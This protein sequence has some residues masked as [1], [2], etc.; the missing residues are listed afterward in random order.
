MS[1][2][3]KPIEYSSSQLFGHE[4]ILSITNKLLTQS[5]IRFVLLIDNSG[6]MEGS[7]LNLVK[8]ACK[9]I[10]KSSNENIEISIFTFSTKGV[11]VQQFYIMNM[12]NKD[13]FIKDIDNI[14][15]DGTTNLDLGLDV[16]M[17]YIENYPNP[18][19][20]TT[21][22]LVFTDGEPDN[23]ELSIYENLLKPYYIDNKNPCTIDVFGFGNSLSLDVLKTIYTIGNGIFGY[24]SDINMIGTIF[25][26][27]FANVTSTTINN[28]TIRYELE[29]KDGE[30]IIKTIDVGDIQ[31]MQTKYYILEIPKDYSLGFTSIEYLISPDSHD[32]YSSEEEKNKNIERIEELP[33]I[34]VE[35]YKIELIKLRINIINILN[36]FINNK[37]NITSAKESFKDVY[38]IFHKKFLSNNDLLVYESVKEIQK[39]LFDIKSNDVQKGQIMRAL[40]NYNTWGKY[41]LI[42]LFQAHLKQNTINFKDDSL[43][44]YS[45]TISKRLYEEFNTIFNT[46][47]FVER[48]SYYS[49]SSSYSQSTTTAA[50]YNYRGGG[51]F[52]ENMIVH[53]MDNNLDVHNIKLKDLKK[54][55]TL[56][57][58]HGKL[59]NIEYIL[60]TKYVNQKMYNLNGL[61]GTDTHPI[62]INDEWIKMKDA[63]DAIEI[64][65]YQGT[66]IYSFSL[67]NIQETMTN[68]LSFEINE[69]PCAAFGHG[70]LDK[71][72]NDK[73]YSIL[74]STFW[75][76]TILNIFR[77]L[78]NN[79]LLIDD[80]LTLDNDYEYIRD[81]ISGWC[82]G[83]K[84]R[85]KIY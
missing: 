8:H 48:N 72:I 10:I 44:I 31:S 77:I 47:P 39:L 55:D 22:L 24:I 59:K 66:Y 50:D 7:R 13:I 21:H 73:K 76:Q 30:I 84:Y 51:C 34:D 67:L 52:D 25:G 40:D 58:S 57:D 81:N 16:S 35:E 79:K 11:M 28:V 64:K 85:N 9:S 82:I 4:K 78:D 54:G 63:E 53:V 18:E 33:Q 74:S 45:G 83:L 6:S 60:K 27:Y 42:S 29:D 15:T 36:N 2:F 43:Q 32:S 41:Y 61:I 49:S 46:I 17:N 37:T 5:K 69:I 62:F 68:S 71:D 56:I 26:N 1:S 75:G 20:I 14:K 12:H 38:N 70:D 80:T 3:V 65:N 19:N 23:K